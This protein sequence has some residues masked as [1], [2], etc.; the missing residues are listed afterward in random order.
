MPC[1][2]RWIGLCV[3]KTFKKLA[4]I[5]PPGDLATSKHS[6]NN[7]SLCISSGAFGDL[8][9]SQLGARVSQKLQSKLRVKV[10]C[11]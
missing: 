2:W 1:M 8:R 4:E 7:E 3:L 5:P 10:M 6:I 9:P 11:A